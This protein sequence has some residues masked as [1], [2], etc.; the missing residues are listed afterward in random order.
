MEK[1]TFK[2]TNGEQVEL[3]LGIPIDV[4]KTDPNPMVST[5]GYGPE[6]TRCGHCNHLFFKSYYPN[7][8]YKCALR[9]NTNGVSTDQRV[10]WNACGKFERK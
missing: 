5:Y 8:Y 3:D 1:E 4:R 6:K 9:K 7:K 10:N 2:W